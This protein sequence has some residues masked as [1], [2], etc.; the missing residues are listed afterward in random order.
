MRKLSTA[1]AETRR[2]AGLSHEALAERAGLSRMTIQRVEAEKIDPRLST[3][4]EMARALGMDMILVPTALRPDLE[5]FVRAGGRFLGQ[6]AGVGAPVS[7]VD[8]LLKSAKPT[9]AGKTK[10][11]Q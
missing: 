5:E 7:L 1:L 9:K 8:E 11:H 6:A 3:L 10:G 2:A 4:E